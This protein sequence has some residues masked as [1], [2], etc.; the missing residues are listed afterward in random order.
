MRKT[1]GNW[2]LAR[3]QDKRKKKKEKKYKTVHSMPFAFSILSFTIHT[4]SFFL[5]P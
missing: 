5:D 3:R 4:F 2:Q 1:V